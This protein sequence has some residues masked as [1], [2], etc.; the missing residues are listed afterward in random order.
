MLST[1]IQA[2]RFS[3][4]KKF[5]IISLDLLKKNIAENVI[6]NNFNT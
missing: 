3:K 5:L 6:S 4:K 1:K 2:E